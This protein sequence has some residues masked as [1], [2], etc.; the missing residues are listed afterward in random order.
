MVASLHPTGRVWYYCQV[1]LGSAVDQFSRPAA[2]LIAAHR[3]L[4]H[5]ATGNCVDDSATVE[6][7][8]TASLGGPAS[9]AGNISARCP[10]VRSSEEKYQLPSAV[11]FAQRTL[12]TA[13]MWRSHAKSFE[14]PSSAPATDSSG[15]AAN[16]AAR[17]W[18]VTI[19]LP[20]W[21]PK[22]RGFASW[23]CSSLGWRCLRGG[24]RCVHRECV[25]GDRH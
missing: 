3:R 9:G 23:P 13:A 14:F 2:L 16:Y 10:E 1:G 20:V 19:C 12:A 15:Y 21:P 5:H 25:L 7:S 8:A 6:V 24:S 11:R 18:K 22:I 17:H 4:L